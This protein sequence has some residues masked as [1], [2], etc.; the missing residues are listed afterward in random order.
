MVFQAE[1]V[2]ILRCTQTV[3][4][5][6]GTGRRIRICS[7]SQAALKVFGAPIFIS[8]LVWTCRCALEELVRENEV[9]LR[10]IL[11]YSGISGNEV[12]D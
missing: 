2:A 8:G 3:L 1:I 11:R 10:W 12:T 6:E 7:D 9:I 4:E 5:R